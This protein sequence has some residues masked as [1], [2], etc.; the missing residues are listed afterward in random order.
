M[1]WIHIVFIALF[2]SVTSSAIHATVLDDVKAQI[3]IQG[4][5]R[6][7]FSQEKTIAKLSK[8]LLATGNFIYIPERGLLWSI[9]KPYASDTLISQKLMVQSV[10]G[11]VILKTDATNQPGYL[12][13]SRIFMALISTDIKALE[14]DFRIAGKIDGSSWQLILTPKSGLFA[15]FAKTITIRGEKHLQQISIAEKNGDSTNYHF[16]DIQLAGKLS[17]D[18]NAQFNLH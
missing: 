16:S 18:E 5:Q 17:A 6:G 9:E 13:V 15:N 14:K 11:K 4:Q 10:K 1:K 2:F 12:A 7:N 3:S 8:P